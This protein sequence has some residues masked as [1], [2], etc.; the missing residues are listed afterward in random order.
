MHKA[1]Y[2]TIRDEFPLSAQVVVRLNSKVADAYK[3]DQKSQREFRKHGSICYD[4]RI[5]SWKM[6]QGFA[7]IWTLDGRQKIP[8]VCGD[9]HRELLAFQ[10]GE[11]LTKL[12]C[13]PSQFAQTITS[14]IRH[15][16][17]TQQG[18]RLLWRW[19][20]FDLSGQLDAAITFKYRRYCNTKSG[21]SSL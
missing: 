15:L 19:L 4:P 13:F 20:Q 10:R 6:D 16:K 2:R 1:F 3:I 18:V 7:S 17:R 21:N 14:R 9:H 5:L 8:F 11:T 12:L